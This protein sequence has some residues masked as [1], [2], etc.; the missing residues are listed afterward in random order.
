MVKIPAVLAA[1][2]TAVVPVAADNCTRGLYYCGWL[3]LQIGG[4]FPQI[5]DAFHNAG[6]ATSRDHVNRGLFYYLGGDNGDIRFVTSCDAVCR[7]AD[8]G[9]SFCQV[10]REASSQP[11]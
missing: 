4:Y 9:N 11:F 10:T 1:L 8:G 3:L 2:S 7:D 5:D 6:L